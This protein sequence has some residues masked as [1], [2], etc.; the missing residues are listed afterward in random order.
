MNLER[1][2]LRTL[3]QPSKYT[4]LNETEASEAWNSI[5]TGHGIMAFEPEYALQKNLPDTMELPG[6]GG[7]KIYV[8]EAY[9]AMHCLVRSWFFSRPVNELMY[10]HQ[11]V[12]RQHYAALERNER[13]GWTHHHDLHCFDTLRQYIMCNIDDTLLTTWGKNDVGRN[14][15]KL[16]HDWDRLRDWAAERL[17]GYLDFEPGSGIKIPER[18]HKE[19][20]LPVGSLS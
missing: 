8:I 18:Y 20:G 6:S 12:M 9:H 4:S 11:V 1:T 3:Y 7:K 10:T 2:E 16:C 14:Q 5:L 19:D 17:E 15:K 13:W